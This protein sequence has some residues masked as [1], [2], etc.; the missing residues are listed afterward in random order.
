MKEFIRKNTIVVAVT[1][2][3]VLLIVNALSIYK[4]RDTI[5]RNNAIRKQS[6]GIIKQTDNLVSYLLHSMDLGLRAYGVTKNPAMLGPLEGATSNTDSLFQMLKTDL[7]E[8]SYD[9]SELQ[10]L[11]KD[12]SDYGTYCF[13]MVEMVKLDSMNAFQQML[14]EDRGLQLWSHW[15][16]VGS[17]ILTY[18]NAMNQEAEASYKAAMDNNLYLQIF[19]LLIGLP[20]LVFIVVKLRNDGKERLTLLSDLEKNNRQYVF[21]P[22]AAVE[23]HRPEEVIEHSI[24]NFQN[25]SQFIESISQGKYDATW[26]ELNET[27]QSLNETNLAGRL[28]K[29]RDQLKQ[30]KKDEEKR[31]WSNEGLTKFTEIVR[32]HQQ[33]LSDLSGEIIIYLTKYMGAQQGGLFVLNDAN[34]TEYLELMA[35]YA[36]DRKKYIERKIDIGVG[37]I[38]QAFLEGETTMLTKVPKGYAYIS[39]GMGETIPG[40]VLIVPLKYN[41]KIE[42]IIELIGLN[43]FEAHEVSFLEKAGEFVAAALQSV[44]TTDRMHHLLTDS[45]RQAEIMRAAEEEMRQNM[46]EL[47]STQEEIQRREIESGERIKQLEEEQKALYL[48]L[49]QEEKLNKENQL[50]N[51]ALANALKKLQEREANLTEQLERLKDTSLPG[52][53]E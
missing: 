22:G 44:R 3:A 5:A 18:E 34:G 19:I 8:Q 6:E 49:Q 15:K 11:H 46:E 40:C 48:K 41:G 24:R 13:K 35:C 26:A 31:L 16:D 53:N 12:F 28:T 20:T 42:A 45:Q 36:Y 30:L 17:K 38:G 25:A 2:V 10:E 33:N 27:N 21:N 39:S 4:N 14:E 47:S 9:V 43:K 50:S 32:N 37:L 52:Y 1:L 7:Q 29:M 51:S 23:F